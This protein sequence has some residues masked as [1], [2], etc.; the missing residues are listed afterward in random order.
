VPDPN[1]ELWP[2]GHAPDKAE[3]IQYLRAKGLDMNAA[4][5][6]AD[7]YHA[8]EQGSLM[9]GSSD[10]EWT[11]SRLK[12]WV[13]GQSEWRSRNYDPSQGPFGLFGAAGTPSQ[14]VE[15]DD[16]AR[17][18]RATQVADEAAGRANRV[19][20]RFYKAG[21]SAGF[22]SGPAMDPGALAQ[23]LAVGVFTDSSGNPVIDPETG[24]AQEVTPQTLW[25]AIKGQ[26][27]D[28]GSMAMP[29]AGRKPHPRAGREGADDARLARL[30][31]VADE[32]RS[33]IT[34]S[35]A[36]AILGNMDDDQVITLQQQ[37]WEAGLF[38]ET[39]P[40]WGVADETTR[41]AYMALFAE[42][43]LTPDDPID[44][45]LARLTDEAVTRGTNGGGAGDNQTPAF[46]PEVASKETLSALI[47]DMAQKLL[48]RFAT[49]DE[50][51]S[52]I[53][54]LQT[55]EVDTQRQQYD[56]DVAAATGGGGPAGGID[57]FMNAI[58]GRESGGDY[59]ARNA[60]SGASGKFQ[61]MPANW[62]PWAERA[63]LGRNA[64]R[65]PANQEIVAKH[66]MTEYYQRF[67]NWRD[68]AIAWFAGPGAVGA[69]GAERRS[70]G[71]MTVRQY[72]D[73]V[74]SRMAAGGGDS[75]SAGGVGSAVGGAIET[76]DP[77]AEAQAALKAQDP[78]GW[79]GHEFA[80]RAPEFFGLLQGVV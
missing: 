59:N 75:G 33:F 74:M 2:D 19:R 64:P 10:V 18:D 49:D 26:T 63:G 27:F 69:P 57:A 4:R 48:G 37:L 15:V 56:R 14:R 76:F 71:N 66:V 39:P 46:K 53:S 3:L 24:V 78:A 21:V 60:S 31:M 79:Q 52:L 45:V 70:D 77:Q 11:E 80:S 23:S 17:L 9:S 32:R 43:S 68:V 5:A 65:T 47:D 38:G 16:Q 61:I 42:A 35:M 44:R 51:D 13:E 8:P 58:A 72:A 30:E 25:A 28:M 55:K 36:M 20:D 67:G 34:P 40:S 6:I 50:K 22:D 29:R 7:R 73:D 62:G 41:K 54:N 12:L 1:T